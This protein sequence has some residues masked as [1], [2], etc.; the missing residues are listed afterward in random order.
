MTP[1]IPVSGIESAR[2]NDIYYNFRTKLKPGLY[3]VRVA[4][5]DEKSGRVGSASQWVEIA[6]LSKRKLAL[7]SLLIGE[8]NSSAEH[9]QSASS[10]S[11]EPEMVDIN[12]SRRF[13]HNSRLRYLIYIYNAMMRTTGADVTLQ[14]QIFR[15]PN[16]ITGTPP[17][18]LSA[19]GQ[20]ASAIP[21]A[22]EVP[23]NSMPRG[24]YTLQVTSTDNNARA[25]ATQQVRFEIE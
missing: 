4:A 8:L 7:S 9:R 3:Q 5:M 1:V 10:N 13:T 15:G 14:T 12:V 2:A 11:S 19:N 20:D 24:H 16:L 18:K 23:L 21:Y 6:D 17:R 25:T 22:A